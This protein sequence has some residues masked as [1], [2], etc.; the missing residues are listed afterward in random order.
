MLNFVMSKAYDNSQAETN[1]LVYDILQAMNF[2]KL[3][4]AYQ[5]LI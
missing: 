1:T 4:L 3:R 2:M 5:L